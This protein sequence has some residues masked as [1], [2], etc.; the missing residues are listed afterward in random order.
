M[1]GLTVANIATSFDINQI[2]AR[3]LLEFVGSGGDLASI[4]TLIEQKPK[5]FVKWVGSKRQLL[6]QFRD[7]SLYPPAMF[8]P[9][10]NTYY[11]PFV[12]GGAFF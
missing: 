11:E 6:K 4:K 8:D 7:L 1:A 9:S 3:N 2:Y 5:P 10:I 12:G